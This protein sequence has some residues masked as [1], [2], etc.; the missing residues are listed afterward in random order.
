[1]R[2]EVP[3]DSTWPI[4]GFFLA[5]GLTVLSR[6]AASASSTS[7][8]LTNPSASN[9]SKGKLIRHEVVDVSFDGRDQEGVELEHVDEG[10]GAYTYNE[11][12]KEQFLASAPKDDLRSASGMSSGSPAPPRPQGDTNGAAVEGDEPEAQMNPQKLKPPKERKQQPQ[13]EEH[14][15]RPGDEPSSSPAAAK[16]AKRSSRWWTL[17]PEPSGLEGGTG[18][19]NYRNSSSLGVLSGGEQ[20]QGK[21]QEEQDHAADSHSRIVQQHHRTTSTSWC[22]TDARHSRIPDGR[23]CGYEDYPIGDR[24]GPPDLTACERKGNKE[25]R[26]YSTSGSLDGWGR[27]GRST[28]RKACDRTTRC[29][30]YAHGYS[31][32]G[33]DDQECLLFNA[34]VIALDKHVGDA[35]YKSGGTPWI[36]R[37]ATASPAKVYSCT[38]T[39]PCSGHICNLLYG[40]VNK[41]NKDDLSC[42]TSS[43]SCNSACCE[44]LPACTGKCDQA[45]GLRNN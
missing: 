32:D 23:L 26:L 34:C 7:R 3:H 39:V 24:P 11:D 45:K 6:A 41:L 31:F 21:E 13:Q 9:P 1:M 5:L 43:T 19:A 16:T 10:R 4:S 2:A 44:Q 18:S 27:G 35:S 22:S 33:S 15:P 20:E 14:R 29:T 25:G 28:C 17:Y 8:G 42:P 36:S 30:H 37:L 38:A 40:W 12:E